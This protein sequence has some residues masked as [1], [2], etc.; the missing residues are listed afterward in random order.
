MK[1]ILYEQDMQK[2]YEEK[3]QFYEKDVVINLMQISIV[4]MVNYLE[5]ILETELYILEGTSVQSNQE[6]LTMELKQFK[7]LNN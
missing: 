6:E 2:I 3:I 1:K 7:K 5:R 4:S